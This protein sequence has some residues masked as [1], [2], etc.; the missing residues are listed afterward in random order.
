MRRQTSD[1]YTGK[2]WRIESATVNFFQSPRRHSRN[3][4]VLAKHFA[5]HS[6]SECGETLPR[7]SVPSGGV[8]AILKLSRNNVESRLKRNRPN[9][10][11]AQVRR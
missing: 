3:R 5:R 9:Q 11:M 8:R 6:G 1:T 10:V 7:G 2:I 4:A